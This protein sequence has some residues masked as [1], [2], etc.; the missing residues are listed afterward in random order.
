M[1]SLYGQWMENW[2]NRLCSVSTNRKVR[3]FEWGLEWT[4]A[5]P[6][7]LK[8]PQNGHTPHEYLSLLNRETLESSDEF[9][10]YAPPTDFALTGRCR[11]SPAP[12]ERR[13]RRTTWLKGNGSRLRKSLDAGG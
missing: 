1:Q 5:W 6:A 3:P 9:F 7:A 10:A 4:R 12:Y 2:E 8:T 13:I 11:R